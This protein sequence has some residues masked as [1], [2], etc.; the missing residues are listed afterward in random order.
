[1][2]NSLIHDRG[3]GPE[4]VGTRVTVFNLLPEFLDPA[5]TELRIASLYSLTPEQVAAARAYIFQHADTVFAQHLQ[6]EQ[7]LEQ[8]NPPE[9]IEQAKRSQ[10]SLLTF[11]Q[12]LARQQSSTQ[13]APRTSKAP[14]VPTFQEWIAEQESKTSQG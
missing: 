8:G 14:P 2:L 1:M 11:K 10:T 12:W 9:V 13:A 6:I 7:K 3:R 5:M 4:I